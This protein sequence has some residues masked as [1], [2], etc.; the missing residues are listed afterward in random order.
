M[1]GNPLPCKNRKD[2]TP[3]RAFDYVQYGTDADVLKEFQCGNPIN[4]HREVWFIAV[5]WVLVGRRLEGARRRKKRVSLNLVHSYWANFGGYREIGDARAHNDLLDDRSRHHRINPW[6][7][8]YPH[9]FPPGKR[10][11]SSRRLDIFHTGHDP[12]SLHLL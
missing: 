9:V 1:V 11:I 3:A 4:T 10:P 6:G 7:C 2:G 12:D 8:R 5:S